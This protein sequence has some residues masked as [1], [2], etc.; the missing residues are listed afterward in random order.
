[1]KESGE[2]IDWDAVQAF[3]DSGRTMKECQRRFGFS[4][5]AWDRAR[6]R[7]AIRTRHRGGWRGGRNRRAEVERLLGQGLSNGAVA[8][9]LGI[10]TATVS[11]HARQLGIPPD[12]RFS[13]RVDWAAVQVAHDAGMSVRRCA[14]KFGFHHGSWHKAV[15]R[16]AIRPR[17]H[18]IPLE[19]LLAKGRPTSRGHLK[20]R[21]INA[22]LKEDR[23]EQCGLNEW[24]GKPLS[25]QLHHKNGDG[26]DNRLPNLSFLCPNCHAQTD[27]WGGR[28]VKR[29][30]KPDLKLIEGGEEDEEAA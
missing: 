3:Y 29:R 15:Q 30:E 20:T 9:K 12:R 14:R 28:N 18:L 26:T 7:G 21:L 17:S 10:S 4:N 22:G 5:G 25:A 16:G 27:N 1:M 8:R 19:E 13:K 24:L 6:R 23:C 2:P 11:Y